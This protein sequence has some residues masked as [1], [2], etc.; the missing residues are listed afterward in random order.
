M[1]QPTLISAH[2]CAPSALQAFERLRL[3]DLMGSTPPG[4][5]EWAEAD[6]IELATGDSVASTG[7]LVPLDGQPPADG[8]TYF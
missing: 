1:T 2:C 6:I 5:L 3:P 4:P 7:A 8:H